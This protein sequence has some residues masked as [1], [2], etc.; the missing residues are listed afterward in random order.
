MSPAYR[1]GW[2][3]SIAALVPLD[4]GAATLVMEL[5]IV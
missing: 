3:I 4:V 1:I 5:A 2:Y